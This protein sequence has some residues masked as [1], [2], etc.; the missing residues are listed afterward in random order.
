M[1]KIGPTSFFLTVLGLVAGSLAQAQTCGTSLSCTLSGN[2]FAVTNSGPALFGRTTST[3]LDAAGI[4]GVDGSGQ[5]C[6]TTQHTPSTGVRGESLSHVGVV[7]ATNASAG[8]AGV[9]GYI[10][11]SQCFGYDAFGYLGAKVGTKEYGVYS[12]GDF[13]GT[14]A[15]YFIEPHPT[16]A[17]KEIRY[18]SLEGPEA[19]TYFRGTARTVHGRAI[20]E[21]PE[22]FRMV[23]DEKGLTV[24]V[25]PIGEM[26][27]IAVVK[28]SLDSIVVHSSKDVEFDYMVNGVR[29]AF[30]DFEAISE[31]DDF[32]PRGPN[33]TQFFT[34]P[35]ESRNRLVATGIYT[36]DGKVNLVKAHEMGW[37]Q[38]WARAA[39]LEADRA[40]LQNQNR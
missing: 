12:G 34:L 27:Q 23:T 31:N 4:L 18:V 1:K 35:V 30:K 24:V 22:S 6:H 40:V 33:D 29:R 25:T 37:D 39:A 3:S 15:K 17:S 32:V 13:G 19:G 28:R 9:A 26:A 36:P 20:I 2:A 16:D 7:G 21:V 14:G 5:T 8:L 38:R 11:N 10:E